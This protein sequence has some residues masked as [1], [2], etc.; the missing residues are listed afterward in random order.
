[1]VIK[2]K[3]EYKKFINELSTEIRAREAFHHHFEIWLEDTLREGISVDMN[4]LDDGQKLHVVRDFRRNDFLGMKDTHVA[5]YD[6]NLLEDG[7]IEIIEANVGLT[8]TKDY[9][10]RHLVKAPQES[11]SVFSSFFERKRYDADDVEMSRVDYFESD[12]PIYD[13]NYDDEAGLLK[14]LESPQ[15][16]PIMEDDKADFP[17]VAYNSSLIRTDRIEENPAIGIYTVETKRAMYDDP[18]TKDIYVGMIDPSWPEQLKM[19]FEDRFAHRK[20]DKWETIEGSI[21]SGATFEENI[22]RVTNTW[23]NKIEESLTKRYNLPQ[24]EALKERI[25]KV[26][27]EKTIEKI[28]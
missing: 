15:H 8:E 4:I 3:G 16:K 26:N 21:Y 19:E 22:E 11:K 27:K 23:K 2:T 25:N 10:K 6:I 17:T 24:Y 7:G 13:I 5:T 14:M 1:M 9:N 28:R 12:C 18:G 20:E